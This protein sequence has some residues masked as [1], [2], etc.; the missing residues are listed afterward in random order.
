MDGA[1]LRCDSRALI[2]RVSADG[3]DLNLEIADACEADCVLCWRCRHWVDDRLDHKSS[4]TPALG[5]VI[6]GHAP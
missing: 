3:E 1:R 4:R 6:I 2:Q 5:P